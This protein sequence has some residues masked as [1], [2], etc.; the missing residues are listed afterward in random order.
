M[1][2]VN[3]SEKPPTPNEFYERSEAAFLVHR[4]VDIKKT[5]GKPHIITVSPD[6]EESIMRMANQHAEAVR[7]TFVYKNTRKVAAIVD[8]KGNL[9]RTDVLN[10][11]VSAGGLDGTLRFHFD[12]GSAFSA[13]K[14][15][16]WST[17][18]RGRAFL[19]FP[20]TFHDVTM[21]DGTPMK[22][23]SEERMN[24]VF[25]GRYYGTIAAP[26]AERRM[27]ESI[28]GI[29]LGDYDEAKGAFLAEVTEEA[30]CKLDDFAADFRPDL[31]PRSFDELAD[32]TSDGLAAELAWHAWA[33]SLKN[34]RIYDRLHVP[35]DELQA[36]M[37]ELAREQQLQSAFSA[38]PVAAA[39]P[40]RPDGP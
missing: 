4:L 21:P 32:M 23:P 33:A 27:L 6:A 39:K 31:K 14:S 2:T 38:Q 18:S 8:A 10:I 19:R 28:G 35:L 15:V 20:L 24:L 5:H 17:S 22:S 29:R 9:K 34:P 40:S 26:Q 36:R 7:G 37:A 11:R 13:K 16:V 30:L 12:D 3:A 1:E 25:A